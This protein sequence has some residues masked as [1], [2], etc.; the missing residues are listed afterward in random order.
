MLF[1]S[2]FSSP[3]V[4][5]S[6]SSFEELTISVL[7]SSSAV[8]S[9]SSLAAILIVSSSLLPVAVVSNSVDPLLIVFDVGIRS[10]KSGFNCTATKC[11]HNANS[12]LNC[13]NIRRWEMN[14]LSEFV[15]KLNRGLAGL[16][17]CVVTILN[18]CYLSLN[19]IVLQRLECVAQILSILLLCNLCCQFRV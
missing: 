7:F 17:T 16:L 3:S 8:I 10:S 4:V 6:S 12:T 5:V 2:I 9:A 18:Y 19:L 14:S 11:V 1:C 13:Y 15:A